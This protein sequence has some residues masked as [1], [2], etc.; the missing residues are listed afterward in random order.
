MVEWHTRSAENAGLSGYEGSS[1]SDGT[2]GN[3][4]MSWHI[5]KALD[6]L[7]AVA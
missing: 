7:W 4:I 2:K 3:E 6:P 5:Q 1:P